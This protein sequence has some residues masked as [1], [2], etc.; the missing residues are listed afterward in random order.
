MLELE[1]S[2]KPKQQCLILQGIHGQGIKI[3]ATYRVSGSPETSI[4]V[5]QILIPYHYIMQAL[6]YFSEKQILLC[7]GYCTRTLHMTT[8]LHLCKAPGDRNLSIS[9]QLLKCQDHVTRNAETELEGEVVSHCLA[10]PYH[11]VEV[12]TQ[13]PC[14]AIGDAVCRKLRHFVPGT[15]YVLNVC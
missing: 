10:G 1:A 6:L 9:V 4:N 14:D 13:S 12:M 8:H 3:L 7:A 11:L 2:E 15:Q 5:Y